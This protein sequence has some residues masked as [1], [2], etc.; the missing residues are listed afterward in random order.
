MTDD[1]KE[2]ELAKD[3][4]TL[5]LMAAV[6]LSDREPKDGPSARDWAIENAWELLFAAYNKISEEHVHE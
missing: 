6:L 2:L 1:E 5:G 3:S 4:R